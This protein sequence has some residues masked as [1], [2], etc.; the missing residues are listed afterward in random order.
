MEKKLRFRVFI[1]FILSLFI[2]SNLGWECLAFDGI[3]FRNITVEEG[4]SQATVETILQ[5][6]KGYIWIGTND[7]LNRYNGYSFEV[8]RED[9][10]DK[11]SIANNYI[12]ALEEDK[13][14]NIWVGTIKGLSKISSDYKTITNYFDSEEDGNLSHYKIGGI[15]VLDDGTILVGTSDGM[16]IYNKYSDSFERIYNNGELSNEDIYSL[17]QDEEG[18]I[19][20]G[21]ANGLNKI[22][23]GSLEVQQY[24]HDDNRNSIGE[25]SI[26]KV[27]CDKDGIVWIGTLTKGASR[28]DTK[29]GEIKNFFEESWGLKQVPGEHIRDFYRDSNNILWISTSN[30]LVRYDEES[31]KMDLYKKKIYDKRSLADDTVFTV[32]E[33]RGGM[34]WVG[35]YGGLS[36]FDSANTIIHY[37]HDPFNDKTINDNMIQGIYEDNDGYLWVG[38]NSKGVN[39]LDRNRNKVASISTLDNSF[40]GSDRINDIT[41]Y[42]KFIF[43]GTSNGLNVI[44]KDTGTIKIYNEDQGLNATNIKTLFIDDKKCL[45]IGTIDGFYVFNIDTG[46]IT[47][48]NSMLLKANIGDEYGSAIFQDSEGFYWLGYFLNGGLVQINPNTGEVKNYKYDSNDPNSII[49]NSIRVITEDENGF[50][51][52]GT[53]GG[54]CKLDKS[55]EKFTNYTTTQG[56]AN[57]TVYGILIDDYNNPWVSTNGGISLYNVYDDRFINLN[58]TDGLQSNE[59]NGE[60]Y[61]KT[62][63][64]EFFFGGING[65]NS[66]YPKDIDQ[67]CISFKVMFDKFSVNGVRVEEIN[68]KK[69]RY[70]ENNIGIQVFLPEYKN[71]KNIRYYY[72]LEGAD[73]EWRVMEGTEVMFSNLAPGNYTFRVKA[74]DSKGRLNEENSLKFR[75]GN[76]PWLS[77]P[78][79]ICYIVAIIFLVRRQKIKV[80]ELDALVDARTKELRNEMMKNNELFE[81]VIK[82]EK[83]KNSYFINLSHELRTPL[84]VLHTSEQL[85]T[86]LN[87]DKKIDNERLEH[88]MSIVRRNNK[89][90]LTLINNLI[91]ISKIENEKYILNKKDNDIVYLVEE[92]ALSLKDYVESKNITFIIDPQIEEKIIKCD[93]VEIERCIVNLISNATKFTMDGGTITVIIEDIGDVVK[94]KVKD[95]GIGIPEKFHDLIFNRFSQV[96]DN[97]S[98][99]KGGSGLG[100]TITKQIINL[101]NGEIYVESKCGVGSTFIIELPSE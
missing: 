18:N 27:Y 37:K 64:G 8:F 67:K 41:G 63:N 60:A 11:N 61:L 76:V 101:H 93:A 24:Y 12:L 34:M 86:K 79:I 74:I 42:D 58:I 33:D 36:V 100:L 16:N 82:L 29:T 56:L 54:L 92:A 72:K 66:F 3:N 97:N 50:M 65:M 48:I 35:T 98:E 25:N 96:V 44:D 47:D 5:D 10:N 89:R 9:K 26:Y 85:I 52:I 38:T 19:W 15:L 4:L 59:F 75:I 46:N 84:N 95:T 57:N 70:D 68:D 45:W 69:F 77:F 53:S 90:L 40:I 73:E 88:Y 91:D 78:A 43:L 22:S 30:G 62:K 31:D 6:K 21:T 7:G 87:N 83:N 32:I 94:I 14:G 23:K 28:I 2:I 99:I 71:S 20:V 39:I 13:D 17:D 49:D 51:W 1:G 80:K 55:T 81:R